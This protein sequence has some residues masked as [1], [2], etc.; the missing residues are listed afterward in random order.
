[1]SDYLTLGLA[2]LKARDLAG[3]WADVSG[4]LIAIVG[5][6]A[7]L[8]G[9]RK[10]KNAAIAAQQAAQATRDSIRLLE[11]IVDFSTAIAVLEE[12]KRA[13]RETGTSGT[14]PERYATI[15]KQ[16][17]VLKGSKVKLS[18]DQLAVIQNAVANLS[19]MENHI[20]RALSNKTAL[21]VAKFNS[22]ISRD[23][24]KLVDVLTALKTDQ[25]VRNGAEQT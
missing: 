9:V 14:L 16:L 19:T 23:I 5:F 15:R 20:E 17:I 4:F 12:I 7:T 25:E 13:H 8:V 1:M 10:S 24:D 2:W 22:I 3:T 18:D 6:G 11:T 21:P